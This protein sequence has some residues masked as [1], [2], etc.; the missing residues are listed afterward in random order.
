MLFNIVLVNIGSTHPVQQ[1]MFWYKAKN[2]S[3]KTGIVPSPFLEPV[4]G[5]QTVLL[6]LF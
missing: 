5:N 4:E 1:L 3:G 6:I 2:E